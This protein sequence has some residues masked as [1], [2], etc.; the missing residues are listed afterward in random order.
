M[1]E[2]DET[3]T[4]DP[5]EGGDDAPATFL[6]E[7]VTP[8]ADTVSEVSYDGLKFAEGTTEEEVQ[9]KKDLFKSLGL[10]EDAALKWLED[11]DSVKQSAVQKAIEE[12]TAKTKAEWSALQQ[13]NLDEIKKVFGDELEDR[14]AEVVLAL[15]KVLPAEKAEKFKKFQRETGLGNHPLFVEFLSNIGRMFKDA[16]INPGKDVESGPQRLYPNSNMNLG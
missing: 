11:L 9:A 4:T 1:T 12:H 5:V 13:K 15:D 8:P 16:S 3:T 14:T 7:A 10:K 6:D 2:Q